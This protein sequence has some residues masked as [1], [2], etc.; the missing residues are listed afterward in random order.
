M[1]D[2]LKLKGFIKIFEIDA[3]GNKTLV[4]E[5][6]NTVTPL[7]KRMALADSMG[8][9]LK[10]AYYNTEGLLSVDSTI[11]KWSQNSSQYSP[12]TDEKGLC[13]YLLNLSEEQKA[14]VN[15]SSVLLPIYDS[16]FALNHEII[17][18]YATSKVSSSSSKEGT[19]PITALDCQHNLTN[20]DIVLQVFRF[21][22]GIATGTYN[23]LAIGSATHTDAYSGMAVWKSLEFYS[24]LI[25]GQKVPEGYYLRHG[26]TI[27]GVQFTSSTQWL[28]GD[29]TSPKTAR[30]I[31]DFATNTKVALDPSDPRYDYPLGIGTFPQVLTDSFMF[32]NTTFSNCKKVNLATGEVSDSSL[33]SA[34]ESLFI[35]NGYLY[36]AYS[37]SNL[38]AF[39]PQTM[40]AV[41]SANINFSAM[42]IPNYASGNSIR[43]GS[44]DETSFLVSNYSNGEAFVCT[45]LTNVGGSLIAVYPMIKSSVTYE[46]NG[47]RYFVR[48]YESGYTNDLQLISS[49]SS[50]SSILNTNR[51]LAICETAGNM[52]SFAFRSAPYEK[53]AEKGIIVEYGYR[54][55]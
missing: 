3:E 24:P 29:P 30:I 52:V 14:T 6:N 41:S 19:A 13:L 28:L 20:T 36:K 27:N 54:F 33:N 25:N 31:L 49:P 47:V 43:V 5:I 40:S 50:T 45:D 51:S 7:G 46:I 21:D 39:N 8:T 1:S 35:H 34:S 10:G 9:R 12:S 53:T 23:T 22:A 32:Y 48:G 37:N 42:N 18:G 2:T 38:R 17:T 55:E 16:N 4:D 44:F 26:V 11:G 15:S